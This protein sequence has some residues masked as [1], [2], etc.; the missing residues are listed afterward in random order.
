MASKKSFVRWIA[1]AALMS[2]GLWNGAALAAPAPPPVPQTLQQQGRILDKDGAPVASTVHFVFTVYDDPAASK[3][4]N[5]L[6]SEEQDI[7]LDDGYFS[8]EL[9]SV[10]AI[11]ADLF[12][13]SSRYLGVT[14]GSDAE[15][16]PRQTISSVPYALLAGAAVTVPFTG[17][18]GVPTA[19]ADG[20]YLKGFGADGKAVCGTLPVLSCHTVIG[21]AV[22]SA[23]FAFVGCPTGEIPTGGGCYATGALTASAFY[24]C[25]SALCL[26]QINQPCPGA[27]DWACYTAAAATITP[28]I[29][30]C[31]VQ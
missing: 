1:S 14:V 16:T 21:A 22:T 5:V 20:S 25:P 26:C 19:C 2:V 6:W 29:R 23:T 10:T 15:M 17:L 7:T 8:T 27:S 31:T 11:P 30:C 9:G 12:D 28:S 24:H 4:A 18:T 13:G 3:P